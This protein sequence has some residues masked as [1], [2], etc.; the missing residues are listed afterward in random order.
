MRWPHLVTDPP[1]KP[2][3]EDSGSSGDPAG[4]SR[5]FDAVLATRAALALREQTAVPLV[6]IA[7]R[8]SRD[9]DPAMYVEGAGHGYRAGVAGADLGAFVRSVSESFRGSTV[10]VTQDGGLRIVDSAI[11]APAVG[12]CSA[13]AEVTVRLID[14]EVAT[15]S[16]RFQAVAA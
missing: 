9:L 13:G 3:H 4:R 16:V 1:A 7:P 14:G 6:M 15:G 11:P 8:G 10:A 2:G 12:E 5:E